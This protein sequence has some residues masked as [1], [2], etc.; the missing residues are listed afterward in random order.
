MTKDWKEVGA[1]CT[2]VK[3]EN[4]GSFRYDHR[5][6]R[7]INRESHALKVAQ[8]AGMPGSVITSAEAV[9]KQL[10]KGNEGLD[11]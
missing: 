2:D 3:E 1:Y 8:L 10:R 4:D 9:L 6:R 7:G 5:M 11:R